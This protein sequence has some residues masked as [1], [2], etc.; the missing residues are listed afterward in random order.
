VQATNCKRA[1]FEVFQC[2]VDAVSFLLGYQAVSLG[3]P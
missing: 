3:D 2:G 1:N